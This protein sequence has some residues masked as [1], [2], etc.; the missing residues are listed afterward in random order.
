MDAQNPPLSVKKQVES[1]PIDMGQQMELWEKRKVC[2]DN[3]G[4]TQPLRRR[5]SIEQ[6]TTYIVRLITQGFSFCF[7][8]RPCVRLP[9]TKYLVNHRQ[10][11]CQ[12]NPKFNSLYSAKRS[13]II[14][15]PRPHQLCRP[16][17]KR[18]RLFCFCNHNCNSLLLTYNMLT[19]HVR[20]EN[21]DI[22]TCFAVI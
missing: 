3:H 2:C 14:P 6:K 17:R 9:A 5:Q 11:K 7:S 15:H 22:A 10:E 21:K 4:M 16:H 19:E 18:N 1:S 12:L 8:K 13:L 20:Y